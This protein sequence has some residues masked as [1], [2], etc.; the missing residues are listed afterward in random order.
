MPKTENAK[1]SGR[2]RGRPR[3]TIDRD[4]VA[5]A[6]AE[7]FHEG[8]LRNDACHVLAA[9]YNVSYSA[10]CRARMRASRR[11][12]AAGDAISLG[13]GSDI[14]WLSLVFDLVRSC[15]AAHRSGSIF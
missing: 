9:D 11:P 10:S 8:E 2:P 5:D 13:D 14:R 12:E 1:T 6:V 15:R 3:L 7:L 4:A